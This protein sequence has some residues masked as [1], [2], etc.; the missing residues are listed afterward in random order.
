MAVVET[1]TINNYIGLSSDTKPTGVP[2]GSRL[3]EIDTN[4]VYIWT[5]NAWVVYKTS[6][7]ELWP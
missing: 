4:D 1:A 5:G 6:G 3:I 7:G 2:A